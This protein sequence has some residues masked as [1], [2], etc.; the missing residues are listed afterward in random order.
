MYITSEGYMY[1]YLFYIQKKYY[2]IMTQDDYLKVSVLLLVIVH[3]NTI[4]HSYYR[5]LDYL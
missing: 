5:S 1:N 3:I 2:R 4:K